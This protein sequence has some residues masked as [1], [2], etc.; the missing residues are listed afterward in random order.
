M[1]LVILATCNLNQWALDFVGNRD[2]IIESIRQAKAKGAALRVGPE[3]EVTGYGCLD[4]FAELDLTDHS[5]E[6]LS[7][8]ISHEDCQ[9]ILLDLGAPIRH[10]NGMYSISQYQWLRDIFTISIS[11]QSWWR[12]SKGG[13]FLI[14][15]LEYYWN[16]IC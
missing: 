12:T 3:L 7:E 16:R 5:W 4:H 15:L 13:K 14:F 9:D 2:R 8:I 6:S 10:R 11:P 1:Q